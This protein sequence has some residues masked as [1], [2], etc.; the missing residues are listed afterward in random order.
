MLIQIGVVFAAYIGARFIEKKKYFK[1][2]TVENTEVEKVA[3]MPERKEVGK[4][5]QHYL[6]MSGAAIGVA[7]IRQF[8]IASPPFIILNLATYSYVAYPYFKRVE[9]SFLNDR[10]IDGYL[11]YFIAD[12]L[13][14]ALGQYL[15]AA[16]G[17]SFFHLA[18]TVIARVKRHS[19]ETLLDVCKERHRKAFGL[20][21][22]ILK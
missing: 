16:I 5:E 8:L 22:K 2:D 14:F 11:L 18:G 4:K 17:A 15:V 7:A 9:K 13:A 1:G 12:T 6:K 21:R 10:K 19:Q 20:S 3:L